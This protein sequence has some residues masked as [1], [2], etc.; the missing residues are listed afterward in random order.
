M[1]G[2]LFINKKESSGYYVAFTDGK[3]NTSKVGVVS[4]CFESKKGY[5]LMIQIGL[6]NTSITVT[7]DNKEL[8][9]V[10]KQVCEKANKLN[11]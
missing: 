1:K 11:S 2:G 7:A 10:A 4:G 9:N 8:Y 3:G 5:E 6:F